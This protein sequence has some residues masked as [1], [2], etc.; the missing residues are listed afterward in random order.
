MSEVNQQTD[1]ILLM[2]LPIWTPLIPPLGISC[3]KSFLQQHGYQ[4]T[5]ADL[6]TK[7]EL[8]EVSSLYFNQ[9]SEHI[10]AELRS[11][12]YNIGQEVMYNHLMA[13][14]NCK[15][16]EEYRELVKILIEKTFFH[17]ITDSQVLELNKVIEL[18]YKTLER[19]LS[20]ILDQEQPSVLGLSVY[21]G[22]LPASLWAFKFAKDKNPHIKTLMGGGIFSNELAPGSPNFEKLLEN[23]VIDKIFIGEGELLLLKYLQGELDESA[24]YYTLQAVDNQILDLS[25]VGLPDFADFDLQSYLNLAGYASRSCP[26]Q[27]KFCSEAV[28]WGKYRKKS[29]KQIAQELHKLYE[30]YG[31]QLFLMGDSLLNPV[32]T[33]LAEEL[34]QSD[35]SVYWDGYL[36]ADKD[37][38]NADNTFLWRR[39]GLYRARIGVESGSERVLQLMGKRITPQQIKEAISNLAQAGI[40]TT[41][42]WVVGYPG[43]TEE[44][45]QQTL[46]LIEELKDDIYE[47]DCNPFT[48]YLTG[49]VNSGEWSTMQSYSLYPQWVNERLLVE[50]RVLDCEPSREETYSRVN[51]LIQFL[52]KLELI[53][54]YSLTDI[55]RADERWQKLHPNAVPSVIEF[56]KRDHYIDENKTLKRLLYNQTTIEDDGEF[57]F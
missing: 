27:C 48:Y 40:K 32:I 12:F 52:K 15:N 5:T 7:L 13:Y 14:Q 55:Y 54:P 28:Q 26:F 1:K 31:F 38:C 22:T 53:N 39:G 2:V 44:D 19:E 43:E 11:N 6:N 24:K 49:Q 4:V 51:R 20:I 18:F 36:R 56:S 30:L 50:K 9:L 29:G 10:P 21:N 35:V 46:K 16:E 33:E 34:I 17:R 25:K 37:V 23:P 8:K 41:T 45:F 47:A 3:L 57:N 42:Y